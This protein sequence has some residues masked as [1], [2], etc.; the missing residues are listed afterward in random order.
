MGRPSNQIIQFHK[1]LAAGIY[2]L[3]IFN[4]IAN[5]EQKIFIE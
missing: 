3:R 2:H 4:A 5:Y 1:K